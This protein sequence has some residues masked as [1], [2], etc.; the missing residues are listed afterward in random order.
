MA[1]AYVGVGS[2]LGNRLGMIAKAQKRIEA[3]RFIVIRKASKVYETEPAGY[4]PQGR[5]LNA[6]WEL[7]TELPP[8]ALLHELTLVEN[9]L[10]RNRGVKNGPRLIDLDL[11]GYGDFISHQGGLTVPHPRLHER[12]FVLKPFSEVNPS[13]RHP[14]FH[15]TVQELLSRIS[16]GA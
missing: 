13:W 10:G 14:R 12:Y 1:L 4:L 5:F 11:L 6:V 7:E 9:Y 15:C 8:A 3:N 2:N 16:P